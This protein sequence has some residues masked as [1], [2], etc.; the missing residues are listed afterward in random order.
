MEDSVNIMF[1]KITNTGPSGSIILIRLMAGIVFLSEG[2]RKFLFVGQIGVGRFIKIGLPFPMRIC[3]IFGSCFLLVSF[4]IPIHGNLLAQAGDDQYTLP[5]LLQLA[6]KNYPLYRSRIFETAAQDK[7]VTMAKNTALPSV[8]A[9]YQLNYATY[10]NITGMADGSY[11]IPISGPPSAINDYNGVF[12]S[13]GSILLNW[14]M[15]TF[16]Q[17]QSRIDL[18]RSFLSL[19][20][21]DRDNELF[22]L[23]L[24]VIN[25]YLDVIM[26]NELMKVYSENLV[27]T[28]GNAMMIR[29][30]TSN[31]LR[32]GIDTAQINSDYS[33]AKI[34]LLNYEGIL[35]TRE[36]DLAG[37]TGAQS[38]SY[39]TDTGFFHHLPMIPVDTSATE[40]PMLRI[41]QG[42]VD[43]NNTEL[44]YV[45]RSMN[46]KLSLWS[47]FY[48]R[49]SG[50]RYDGYVSSTDGLTFSRYNY[51]IG[52]VFSVPLTGMLALRPEVEKQR[53]E[54]DAER[55]K[56]EQVKLD[57]DNQERTAEILLNNKIKIARESPAFYESA[58]YSYK[59]MTARYEAGLAN[60]PDLIQARYS[61]VKAE[62]ELKKSYLEVWKAFLYRNAI[63]GDLSVFLDQIK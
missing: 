3:R 47:S 52:L 8:F 36:T 13:M 32:P 29:T 23:K 62:T 42:K 54:L 18:A 21:A 58:L 51:G 60:Y 50:I 15:V 49:G 16:G 30:L 48:A 2:I 5:Q 1:R 26:A 45:R 25:A 11:S 59:S 6:E 37:L 10:N 40:N 44:K 41:S 9:S 57:L 39:V 27:R 12:G 31:G 17:R 7:A 53:S 14:E 19:S 55:E 35:Q 63:Q 43:I 46:P 34:Q 56:A 22:Q 28:S 4:L 20:Q 61:L 33:E 24:N 38:I